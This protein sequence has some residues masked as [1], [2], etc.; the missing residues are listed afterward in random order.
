MMIKMLGAGAALAS[1]TIAGAACAQNAFERDG[2]PSSSPVSPNTVN[3]PDNA[4]LDLHPQNQNLAAEA[5][6]QAQAQAQGPVVYLNGEART[7]VS[8]D[9]AAQLGI[10]IEITASAPVPDTRANRARYGGPMSRAGRATAPI[11]N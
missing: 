1:L 10:P 5:Q 9:V 3:P 7:A 4:S 8:A 6:F 11:G 2:I